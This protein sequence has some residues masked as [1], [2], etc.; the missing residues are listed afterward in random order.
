VRGAF[1]PTGAS[2]RTVAVIDDV[3]TTGATAA[4]AA[5]ALRQAGARRVEAIAFARAL[6]RT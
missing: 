2:P 6:R 1:R 5:S 3:Y 4:A